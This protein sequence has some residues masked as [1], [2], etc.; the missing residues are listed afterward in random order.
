MGAGE[1]GRIGPYEIRGLLGRGGMSTVYRAY[2]P[3]LDREVA[4]KVLTG[5]HAADPIFRER[6]R[7]EARAVARLRHPNILAV[8]DSGEAGGEPYL[9]SELIEGGTLQRHL[10]RPLDPRDV[11]RLARQ[12][13]AALDYAHG[14]G[15]IHRDVKPANIFVDGPRAV[16]GDFG[17]VKA[18]VPGW[19]A[20]TQTGFGVGTPEYMAPEQALNEPLD[21]RADLYALGAVLYEALAGTP[22]Y[23]GDTPLQVIEGH[24]Q[25]RLPRATERNPALAPEVEAVLARALA[26]QPADRYP[27]GAALADALDA[28]VAAAARRP[29][30]PPDRRAR[31]LAGAPPESLT[32]TRAGTLAGRL[33]HDTT[34]ARPTPTPALRTPAPAEA[35]PTRA[36]APA[37][38]APTTP[39]ISPPVAPPPGAWTPPTAAPRRPPAVFWL[40]GIGAALM[41]LCALAGGAYLLIGGNN[42]PATATVPAGAAGTPTATAPAAAASPTA[43]PATPTAD[44]RRQAAAS[45]TAFAAADPALPLVQEG[46]ALTRDGKFS[47]AKAKYQAALAQNPNSALAN[48]QLGH[49]LWIWNHDPGEIDYLDGA[50]KLAPHDA[51]AWAY[52]S[53]SAVDTYQGE[54][55]YAAAQQAARLDP[56]LPEA[57]AAVANTYVRYNPDPAHPDGG[58]QTARQAIDHAKSLDPDNIW[59][60]WFESEVLVAEGKGDQALAPL[61]RAIAERPNWPTLYYGKGAV[62]RGLGR[63]ADAKAQQEQALALD[64]DYPYAHAELGYLAYD[65]G[66]YDDAKQEFGKALA[67]TD[68]DV[69]AHVGLG[70]TLLAQQDY[71]DARLHFQ[72]AADIDPRDPDARL[73]LGDTALAQRQYADALASYQ[74]VMDDRPYLADGY[75]GAARVYAAQQQYADA[76][77][78]LNDGL[79]KVKQPGDIQFWLGWVL[80]QE[81]RYADAEPHFAEAARLEP[82]DPYVQYWHGVDLERLQRWDEARAAY[83]RALDLKP[84]YQDAKDALDALTKRGH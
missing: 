17:I 43:P 25:G 67:M 33:V 69:S 66:R 48:R 70:Y 73:G 4:V 61:D 59:V 13:G 29:P 10:G 40:V 28:A 64:P 54:R 37:R 19:T 34:V 75:A 41:F 22:P 36:D 8:Y 83:Q 15:L 3:A 31:T 79:P 7:R 72:R 32:D 62:L 80:V 77:R 56:T 42:A 23:L 11:A 60:L 39:P 16:L 18:S 1:A 81:Q 14:Q 45:A 71:A 35:P 57:F 21:G 27:T 78:V 30:P 58:I 12:I 76:E 24:L 74:R 47:E 9:V 46:D 20:L 52:L 84:D 50:T 26:R 65:D 44:A 53:F 82:Q 5:S 63:A 49:M 6:F 38:P 55:A 51:L 2:Q 68:I